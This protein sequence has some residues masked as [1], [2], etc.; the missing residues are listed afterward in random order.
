MPA[1]VYLRQS[2]FCLPGAAH[3]PANAAVLIGE[4]V[5][6]TSLGT[7]MVVNAWLDE[8]GRKLEGPSRRLIIPASK[9]DHVWIEE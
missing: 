3:V 2:L 4:I 9:L 6:T 8:R 5:E 1:H 7:T